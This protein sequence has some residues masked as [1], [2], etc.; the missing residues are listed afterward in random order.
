MKTK[1]YIF[2][3]ILLVSILFISCKSDEDKINENDTIENQV[4]I[5]DTLSSE[6]DTI[7]NSK[8]DIE[9][10]KVSKFICPQGDPEGNSEIAGICPVCE[11]ELIENPDFISKTLKNK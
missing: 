1:L 8:V 4:K 9:D 2:V 11:M 3:N 10:F 5:I 6:F 7:K